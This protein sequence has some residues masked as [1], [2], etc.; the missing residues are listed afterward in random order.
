MKKLDPMN[1]TAQLRYR[2]A[3]N[4]P[5]S[6]STTAISN[7]FPGLEFD[8]RNVWKRIF[9]GLE[10]HEADNYVVGFDSSHPDAGTDRKSVV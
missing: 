9:V 8:F 6:L 5:A 2:A 10:M 7:C 4:P 3:G 1:L